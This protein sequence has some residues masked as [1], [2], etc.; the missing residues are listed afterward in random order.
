VLALLAFAF[1]PV[2][3]SAD[4]AGAEYENAVPTPYGG[5]HKAPTVVG[6]GEE[7]DAHASNKDGGTGGT[8]P[9]SDGGSSEGGDAGTPAGQ[10][11]D[12][13]KGGNG[14]TTSQHPNGGKDA[15]G[16]KVANFEEVPS[17]SAESDDGGSSPL[18]PIL[19][20]IALLAA[21]SVGVVVWQRRRGD[22]PPIT[23][24]AG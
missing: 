6:G 14:S 9:G 10:D 23:P 18:V 16:S 20:V 3:A 22:S 19:I 21:I 4:S 7:D 11:P 1:F 2:A 5:T 17:P 15:A 12:E 8:G 13:N 24:K